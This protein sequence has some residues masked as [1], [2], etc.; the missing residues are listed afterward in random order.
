M[1][2]SH[3]NNIQ[4]LNGEKFDSSR[5]KNK[6]FQFIINAKHVIAGRYYIQFLINLMMSGWELAVPKVNLANNLLPILQMSLGERAFVTIPPEL[7]FGSIRVGPQ[8]DE[9]AFI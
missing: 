6:P 9:I 3:L 8:E 1:S 2:P 4:L 5:E 7:G